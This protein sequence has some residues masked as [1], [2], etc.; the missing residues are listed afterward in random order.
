[1]LQLV[2]EYEIRIFESRINFIIELVRKDFNNLILFP[3]NSLNLFCAC[4]CARVFLD[5]SLIV[6]LPKVIHECG[7]LL[8]EKD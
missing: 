2:E 1:M 4:Y 7:V 6:F 3:F 8:F 5:E